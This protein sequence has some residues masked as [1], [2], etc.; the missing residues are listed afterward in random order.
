MDKNIGFNTGTQS[1]PFLTT[2]AGIPV[3]NYENSLLAGDQGIVAT[4]RI[5]FEKQARFN[6][7]RIPERVVHARG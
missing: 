7:E 4:D 2:N 1:A 3:G 5:F 6:R